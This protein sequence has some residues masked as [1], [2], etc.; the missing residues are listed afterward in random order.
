MK[1]R[2]REKLA[3]IGDDSWIE[4]E[5]GNKV[6]KVDGKAFRVRQTFELKDASGAEVAKIQERKLNVRDTIAIERGGVKPVSLRAEHERLTGH[7]LEA[8][9]GGGVSDL[10]ERLYVS[11]EDLATDQEIDVTVLMR[12]RCFE[13]SLFCDASEHPNGWV[14]SA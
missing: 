11:R 14:K 3:S 8:D 6:Y 10:L 9:L 12:D 13:Q 4:D 1:Y 5:H 7:D 2:M